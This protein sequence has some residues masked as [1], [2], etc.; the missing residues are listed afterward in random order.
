MPHV[1]VLAPGKHHPIHPGCARRAASAAFFTWFALCVGSVAAEPPTKRYTVPG[2]ARDAEIRVDRW[3]VPHIYAQTT[4]DAFFVQGFNAARDRLWQIDL[5]RKR[6]LGELARDFGPAYVEHDAAARLF[7]YR[8]EMHAEWIA[9]ASDAKRIVES[10]VA[11][12]NAYVGLTRAQ[13]ELLAPEFKLLG[14]APAR[15][16]AADVVRIRAHGLASNLSSEVARARTVAAAGLEV[17]AFRRPLEPAWTTQVPPG[18]DPALVPAEVLRG[19]NLARNPVTFTPGKLKGEAG[20]ARTGALELLEAAERPL[21]ASNNFAVAPPRSVTGRAI[22]ASDPHRVHGIPSLRYWAHLSAPGLDVIGAGEP[23]LPGVSLGHN[24]TLAF[25]L[26][27]FAID[28]EDLYVYETNPSLPDEY[29]YRGRW[30][31]MI[32]RTESIAVRNGPAREVTL[33]FTRHGPVVFEDRVNHRAFAARLAWLEPGAV[34]YLSS[35]EYLRAQNWDEFLAAMNRHCTPPLNYL[36]ADTAGNIGW[37]PS[38]LAPIRPNWDGLM[39]VPGDGR[40]EWTGFRSMDELPRSYNPPSGWLGT[41]N[42]MNLPSRPGIAEMKLSFEWA[43]PARALRLRQL[44]DGERRFTVQDLIAA[45]TDVTTVTGQRAVA[46]LA[47]L[48]TPAEPAVGNALQTLRAWDHRSTRDSTGAAIFNVWFHR[49]LRPAVVRRVVPQS[50]VSLIGD[51]SAAAVLAL[52]EKPNARLGSNPER[53]RDELLIDALR[54]AAADLTKR[55]G[56]D[57]SQWQWGRLHHARF[58]HPF[59]A[60]A[61]EEVRAQWNVGPVSKAGDGETLGRSGWRESDFRL[62]S[63]ASARFVTDV[64][65]W[66]NSWANNSPGQSGDPRSPHYRDLFE[67]WAHDRYFPLLFE[68]SAVEA[69]TA[70]RIV[71]VPGP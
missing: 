20:P 32:L 4:Y 5:W 33:K 63:G 67:D 7:L 62:T 46:L 36:Y 9:Y 13:P 48:P 65:D 54:A 8:G 71:L 53:A 2:L 22:F 37:A 42:E 23:F 11:G 49:H 26:T 41:A 35:L 51:G 29:R 31:P 70:E 16:E 21:Y 18:L 55:L 61:P 60:L 28:Q 66:N 24:R 1:F 56:A 59:A 68:R 39:P 25:G 69:A 6:G 47:R 19:Y 34:P 58:E 17:D 15:W 3:G 45:Q 30:E 64:G 14:Y 38:G 52:L 10:F 44:F 27:I 12:I 50:A 57:Q 43:D 40:Y